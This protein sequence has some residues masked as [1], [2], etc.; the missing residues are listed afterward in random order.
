ML[1]LDSDFSEKLKQ[2]LSNPEAMSKISAIASGLGATQKKNETPKTENDE[3]S[4][5]PQPS[6]TDSQSEMPFSADFV[7][8]L[9]QGFSTNSDPRI[10]LLSSI[11]PLLR[12]EKRDKIDSITKALALANMMKNLR[13]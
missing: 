2:I 10:A 3:P 7:P 1:T 5:S 8:A 13:K 9:M 11:K 4:V 6:L 12:E